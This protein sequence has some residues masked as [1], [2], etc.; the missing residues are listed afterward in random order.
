M[1]EQMQQAGSSGGGIG[2]VIVMI[3]YA[4]VIIAAIVAWY[5]IFTKAGK[6]GWAAIVPIYNYYVMT[7]I[8]GRP[9][10]WFIMILLVP[11]VNVVLLIIVMMDI[12]KAF[13]KPG[14]AAIVPIY[15][16]VVMFQMAFGDATYSAPKHS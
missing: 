5:K 2:S 10:S 12:F 16:I 15:N 13:G 8:A 6:P 1:E 7:E 9:M 3:I 14:W 4:A 11:C